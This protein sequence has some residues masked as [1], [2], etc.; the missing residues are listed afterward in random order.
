ML[1]SFFLEIDSEV[2]YVENNLVVCAETP[3]YTESGGQVSDIGII[4][5]AGE[6]YIVLEMKKIAD[7]IF[8][9]CDRNIEHLIGSIAN[10]KVDANRR[11]DIM[12]NHSATHLLHE[13]LRDVLGNHI[14]QAGSLVAPEYLRFDFNH[15]EKVNQYQL[16]EIEKLVNK[17]ILENINVNVEE[18]SLEDAKKNSKI[19][20]FFG[21]KYGDTVRVITMDPKFS[22]ELC[23]GTHV[24]NTSE[25]ALFK[26]I[27][28]SSVAAGI[29][30]VEAITGKK[31][32]EYIEN[33]NSKIN[34]LEK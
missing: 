13:S 6:T 33:L 11:K 27:S 24:N 21:D 12:R 7:T 22:L 29:R 1:Y 34:E 20:M 19:K 17:K 8:H 30:R 31:V 25:I 9:I 5:L 4:I 14:Q 3:F 16:N 28:E 23:G 26:I 10:L 2:L 15:F 18:K 32:I